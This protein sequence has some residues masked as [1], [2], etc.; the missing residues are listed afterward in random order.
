MLGKNQKKK[1]E[2]SI[3]QNCSTIIKQENSRYTN[4]NWRFLLSEHTQ[5]QYILSTRDGPSGPVLGEK[6][7]PTNK[8]NPT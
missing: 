2:P 4:N 3:D 5:M 1:Q 7:T 6:N 8:V